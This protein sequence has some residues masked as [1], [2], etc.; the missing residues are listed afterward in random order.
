MKSI[1]SKTLA[2]L[3][4]LG[5]GWS[6]AH[7][8]MGESFESDGMNT[9]KKCGEGK[10]DTVKPAAEKC[11]SGKATPAPGK[12]NSAKAVE[13]CGAGK[14]G[15]NRMKPKAAPGKCGSGSN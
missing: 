4:T 3:L 10:A 6:M 9:A 15:D 1:H 2:V 11:N 14:C 5:L 7:A 13:K 12:C 8:A